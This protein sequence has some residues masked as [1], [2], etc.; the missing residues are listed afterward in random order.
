[1]AHL[2][3]SKHPKWPPY[4]QFPSQLLLSLQISLVGLEVAKGLGYWVNAAIHMQLGSAAVYN[5]S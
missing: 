2:A 4:G 1:M 5:C 3:A